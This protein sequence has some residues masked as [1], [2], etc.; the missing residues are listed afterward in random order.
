MEIEQTVD[1]LKGLVQAELQDL[2]RI[3]Y[4][5]KIPA[6]L[7]TQRPL[8]LRLSIEA[9]QIELTLPGTVRWQRPIENGTWL[10]GCQS[11]RPIEWETLGELFLS[12][13][14]STDAP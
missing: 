2:S 4:L 1:G 11:D 3:G 12:G 7:N 8:N 6:P 13:V 14:L 10:A 9:S 5:V